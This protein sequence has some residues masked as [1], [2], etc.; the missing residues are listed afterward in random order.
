MSRAP[1]RR[2][3]RLRLRRRTAWA[4]VWAKAST[5]VGHAALPRAGGNTGGGR[6]RRRRRRRRHTSTVLARV[7]C[8][9]WVPARA[10]V[11]HVVR[12]SRADVEGLALRVASIARN[13]KWTRTY[14][15]GHTA[16]LGR[17]KGGD[18][19]AG[20]SL[21]GTDQ[22]TS[23]LRVG[24]ATAERYGAKRSPNCE[25]V[26]IPGQLDLVGVRARLV[27]PIGNECA[28]PTAEAGGW[29]LPTG[30]GVE[31][32][33]ARKFGRVVEQRPSKA[34]Q[35]RRYTLHADGGIRTWAK[36]LAQP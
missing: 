31:P 24:I 19:G 6:G 20:M 2:A 25:A 7:G 5:A 15:T 4:A 27:N 10:A 12:E 36:D 29:H 18:G 14:V 22:S 8:R 35:I 9:T 34:K 11:V 28:G 21:T 3:P 1:I 30:W 13:A 26:R 17:A 32:T 33:R 23:Y 16:I